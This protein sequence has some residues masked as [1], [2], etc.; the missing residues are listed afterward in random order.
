MDP[1]LPQAAQPD[2][3]RINFADAEQVERWTVS[4][5]CT[6]LELREVVAVVGTKVADIVDYLLEMNAL[7][8]ENM[9]EGLHQQRRATDLLL[10]ARAQVVLLLNGLSE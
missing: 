2:E 1:S 5:T 4:L 10:A 6:E 3:P 8:I 9:Q 7:E